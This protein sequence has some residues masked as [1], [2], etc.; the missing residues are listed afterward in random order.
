LTELSEQIAANDVQVVAAPRFGY[1][2]APAAVITAPT[3]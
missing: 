3:Q 1:T 2:S